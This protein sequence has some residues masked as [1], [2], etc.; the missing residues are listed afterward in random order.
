LSIIYRIGDFFLKK[1]GVFRKKDGKPRYRRI[2]LIL[3]Y[4]GLL[5][6]SLVTDS[7]LGYIVVVAIPL[8]M[9]ETRREKSRVMKLVKEDTFR[10]ADGTLRYFR[11]TL[12]LAYLAL[13]AYSVIAGSVSDFIVVV[14]ILLGMFETR[15]REEQRTYTAKLIARARRENLT[16]RPRY[17]GKYLLPNEGKVRWEDNKHPIVILP[18]KIVIAVAAVVLLIGVILSIVTLN[19]APLLFC[20]VISVGASGLAGWK[21]LAWWCEWRAITSGPNGRL[22]VITGVIS[23]KVAYVKISDIK[24]ASY[25][26]PA[27]RALAGIDAQDFIVDSPAQ[28]DQVKTIPL[29]RG[30]DVNNVSAYLNE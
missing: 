22:I 30:S 29:V 21:I 16:K 5:I 18:W 17:L 20:F 11:V 13:L 6:F 23:R 3:A 19:V 4:I 24:T 8:G 26:K 28:D 10:K 7:T 1:D 2:A 15:R 14:L 12:L 25:R 27:S 9:L